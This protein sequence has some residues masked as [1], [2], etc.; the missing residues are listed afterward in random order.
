MTLVH[1]ID[2]DDAVRDA[3]GF[4]LQSHGFSTRLHASA[5]DFLAL[6]PEKR[7]G[8]LVLD[9]RM[10]GLSGIA[11]FAELKT[12]PPLQPVIFLTGHGDVPLAVEAIKAGAF[13]FREKPFEDTAFI[14]VVSRAVAAH[15]SIAAGRAADDDLARQLAS[16]SARERQV[17]EL[18]LMDRPNKVIAHEL[19]ITMRTVEVHRA[20]VLAKMNVRSLVAL[21][22]R[23]KGHA[24]GSARDQAV[25][26]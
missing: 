14:A 21:A 4:L 17:M 20:R 10:P 7:D 25:N 15:Q 16:L 24:S 11:L 8:V 1:V 5:E 26:S 12:R 13:D 6:P 2:D 23:L 18:M 9:I 3:L 22:S 19:G